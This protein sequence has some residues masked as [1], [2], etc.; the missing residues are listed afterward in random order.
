[1]KLLTVLLLMALAR[2]DAAEP[3]GRTPAESLL[4]LPPASPAPTPLPD[5]G[6]AETAMLAGFS[7]Q[8]VK[9]DTALA[10]E[11]NSV[12]L[13]SQR[14][15]ANLFLGHATQAVADFEKMIALDPT[16]DAP[17]WRLGIAYYFAGDFAKSARHFEKYHAY[18]GSDRENGIW[19]FLAQ[20]KLE[21]L[22]KA[23][24]GMLVYTR[25]DR[26]PF[27]ELYEMFS[28]KRTSAEVFSEVARKH[29]DQDAGVIFFARYY[30]GLN[31][32]LLGHR[33]EALALLRQAIA[34]P[35]AEPGYMWQVARLHTR[36]LEAK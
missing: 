20:A 3:G 24:A 7:E 21:G 5:A 23:R 11:P 36:R 1:M 14:G 15:D 10:T 4:A 28:G 30:S 18:D 32:E 19:K 29:L 27:P 26:E 8:V 33:E 16:Q 34:T 13:H 9:C 25:F 6:S 12:A 17:H 22:E 31:E 2:L 35:S